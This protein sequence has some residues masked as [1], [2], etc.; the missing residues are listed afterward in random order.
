MEMTLF[1]AQLWGP[2]LLALGIGF[3][4]SRDY[5]TKVYRDLQNETLALLIFGMAAI[6]AG[7]AQVLAHNAWGTLPEIIVTLLGWGLLIK[8][9]TFAIAPRYVDRMGNWWSKNPQA[10][11]LAGGVMLIVG[12]YLSYLGYFA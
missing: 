4:V 10:I 2:A 12:A 3:F 9:A 5:Y 1:L 7:V 8:G 6:A 11:S